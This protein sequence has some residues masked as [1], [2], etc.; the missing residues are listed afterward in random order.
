M[1]FLFER[2]APDNMLTK[3]SLGREAAARI[4]HM[5]ILLDTKIVIHR[6][7]ATVINEDIGV[8]FRWLDNLHYTKCIHPVTAQE[9]ERHKDPKV[10]KTI[11]TKLDSYNVLKTISPVG[12][13]VSRILGQ[14]D[15]SENDRND[16]LI[17]NEVFNGRV[18]ALISEDK[19]LHRKGSLLG[20]TDRV[21]HRSLS[22]E[23]DC[24]AP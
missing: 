7:A 6:E 21:H 4:Q 11:R 23:G 19:N 1:G 2:L 17:V 22:G 13:E 3:K 10:L 14:L 20:I 18:D 24:G 15:H 16:T 8:L 12:S 9:I 5:R